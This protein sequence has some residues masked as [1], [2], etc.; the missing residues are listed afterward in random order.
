MLLPTRPFVVRGVPLSLT[1]VCLAL[2]SPAQADEPAADASAEV[3]FRRDVA[4]VLVDRCLGCHGQQDAKGEYQLHNFESLLKEGYSG[5]PVVTPGKADES[6]L[7]LLVATDDADTRMPKEADPLTA[8]QVEAIKR[9][10][11]AG[12]K[13]DGPDP[14]AALASI[15]PGKPYPPAP[16]AYRAPLA[17]TALAFHPSGNELAASG[18]HEVT[19]WNPTDGALLRRIGNVAQRVYGLA[20][21][22]DGSLLAIASGT[23]GQ[24]GDV[25][26][27]NPATGELVR[28]LGR[29]ADVVYGVAFNPDGTRLAAC[30]A[31]RSIRVYDVATGEQQLLIE[32]HADWVLAVAW[33]PDGSKLA[34][35]SRDKTSKVFDAATGDSLATFAGHGETVYSVSF[36]ADGAQVLTGGGNKVVHIW[37]PADAAKIGDIGGYGGDVTQILVRGDQIYSS[38]ADTQ[39]RQH[40]G[41]KREQVRVYAGHRDWI[42]SLTI[43]EAAG[44]LA[45]GGYDGEVRVWNLAD[46]AQTAAFIVS[47]GLGT[48]AAAQAA[49]Q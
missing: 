38:S 7:Y 36:N 47:P 25:R 18:Y 23:P 48:T 35:A 13:F 15:V 32:D 42:Y 20:Y 21:N 17:V 10:I 39:A 12:A 26:L 29:M 37:N 19:L 41:E 34:S 31:D 16:Q 3:S 46:G 40:G 28:E 11:D 4:P 24:V 44:R 30:S 14:T 45:T 2:V 8:E 49:A 9:W 43:S 6:E 22:H 5:S 1:L 33:S 27:V